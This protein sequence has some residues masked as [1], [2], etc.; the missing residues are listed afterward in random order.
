[1]GD[2]HLNRERGN[3]VVIPKPPPGGF[4]F[5]TAGRALLV[6][7]AAA[8]GSGAP[9]ARAAPPACAWLDGALV[10]EQVRLLWMPAP[11]AASYKVYRDGSPAGTTNGYSWDEDAP[12]DPGVYGYEVAPLDEAGEEGLRTPMLLVRVAAFPAPPTHFVP[13]PEVFGP[14]VRLRWGAV[15]GAVSYNLY[16]GVGTGGPLVLQGNLS[17]CAAVDEGVRHGHKYRYELAAVDGEGREGERSEPAFVTV[18]VP[19]PC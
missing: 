9:A 16:R 18:P 1:M 3:F 19:G 14:K 2:G 8:L 10:G 4:F 15:R 11:A 7:L 6:G 12:R 5:R 13:R 17:V